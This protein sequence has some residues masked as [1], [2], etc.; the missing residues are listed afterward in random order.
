MRGRS[1]LRSSR[2][3]QTPEIEGFVARCLGPGY[4]LHFC[5][6]AARSNSGA[7]NWSG[8]LGQATRVAAAVFIFGILVVGFPSAAAQTPTVPKLS[9][10]STEPVRFRIE[11]GAATATVLVR[12]TG[13]RS[14]SARVRLFLNDGTQLARVTP[15][16]FDIAQG[17][18]MPVSITVSE[19]PVARGSGRLVLDESEAADEP[20]VASF[21][22]Q[23][24]PSSTALW[25]AVVGAFLGGALLI[26]VRFLSLKEPTEGPDKRY[27]TATLLKEADA[28]WSFTQ[29]W[30]SN[31]TALGAILGTVLA[32]SGWVSQTLS[33]FSTTQFAG[34]SLFFGALV[35][36][37]PLAY[38]AMRREVD[39]EDAP[40]T[41]FQYGSYGGL[42]LAALLTTWAVLGQLS[43]LAILLWNA[44]LQFLAQ[45]GLGVVL[46][47]AL[48]ILVTYIWRSIAILVVDAPPPSVSGVRSFDII[49]QEVDDR[50][51]T[52]AI[53]ILSP[54]PRRSAIL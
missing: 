33:E 27:R 37:A 18:I 31:I 3:V 28:K 15:E 20:A 22:L 6:L 11:D 43:T 54:E 16:K 50:V 9:L 26:L 23:A 10:A 2:T 7:R 17:E 32:A 30:A 36:L 44:D 39:A 25:L 49:R 19:L 40:G 12:N 21:S 24:A 13:S 29:S 14:S 52:N 46:I 34:L 4:R 35:L 42:L 5:R 51:T 53:I 48:C 8:Y 45:L 47:A 38:S 41:D 1:H